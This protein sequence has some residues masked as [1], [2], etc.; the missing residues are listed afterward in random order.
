[1]SLTT[2]ESVWKLQEALRAKAKRE[3]AARFHSLYDKIYRK[4]VLWHAWRCCRAN[5]GAP[6][7][8]G[9]T[10]EQIEERGVTGWLE[11]LIRELR[12]GTYRPDAVLRV[13]IPKPGSTKQRPLGVPYL[14]DRVI[15]MAAGRLGPSPLHGS[16]G[17]NR[18][19]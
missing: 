19:E 1:M 14:K 16:Y 12:K 8:D 6:G 17:Q 9:V 18:G 11:E 3:P 7:V 4:D 5:G 10:F 13:W 2:P 15:Q